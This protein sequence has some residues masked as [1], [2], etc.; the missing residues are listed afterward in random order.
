MSTTTKDNDEAGKPTGYKLYCVFEKINISCKQLIF[1]GEEEQDA[2][3]ELED[4]GEGFRIEGGFFYNWD[5]LES[6][7]QAHA[8]EL[9]KVAREAFYAGQQGEAYN[10]DMAGYAYLEPTFKDFNDWW[11]SRKDKSK[12]EETAI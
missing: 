10:N 11:A 2:K 12:E 1:C 6:L 9:E 7:E 3:R 4:L 8:S 5:E